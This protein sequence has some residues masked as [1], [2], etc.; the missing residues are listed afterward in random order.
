NGEIYGGV[1]IIEDITER[2][3][4]Q[5][6]QYESEEKYRLIFENSPL[7]IIS[8]DKNGVITACNTN[9][10]SIIG[11]STE[12]LVGLNMLNLPDKQMIKA[13][14]DSLKGKIG[15]YEGDYQSVTASKMTPVRCTFSPIYN[16]SG[17]LSGGVG[18][19]EDITERK[20]AEQEI[21]QI[22]HHYKAIIE[23]APD[24]IVL[25]NAEGKFMDVSPS[26]RRIF[27]FEET[28]VFDI[29]PN[30]FTHPDDLPMVLFNLDKLTKDPSFVPTLEYRFRHRN[31]DWL[32]IESTFSN[33]FADPAVGAIII[34]FR[35]INDRKN[36]EADLIESETKYRSLVDY[37]PDTIV[38]HVNG[39]IV[40]VNEAGIQLVGAASLA[41][42]LGKSVLEFVHPDSRA[43]VIERMKQVLRAGAPIP[44][45]EEVFLRLDGSTVEVDVK[46]MPIQYG[47]KRA[48][49][50]IIR[51][52]T[53]RKAAEKTIIESEK[54]YKALFATSPS[55][56]TIIDEDGIIIEINQEITNITG[57]LRDELVGQPIHLLG[58]PEREPLVRDNI[59]RILA[60]ETLESEVVTIKK[61]GTQAFFHL[62]E[63]AIT[64]PN[65][66]QGILSVSNDI[67]ARKEIEL[68]LESKMNDLL[69]FQRLTTGREL[70][71]IELK[72][73]I[74]NLLINIGKSPKYKIVE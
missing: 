14:G 56:I 46:S 61:D 15:L 67:S 68:E 64:L 57:Y 35:D 37:S 10:V 30:D 2:V 9:F 63:A 74:N 43:F 17:E 44:L 39:E 58:L 12:K 11:S 45:A 7:G 52:I 13:V 34:N 31:G 55:G 73:E 72:K 18:I 38:I 29:L 26:A 19:I 4:A 1:G 16:L 60:G 70:A 20:L 22:V 65:G 23:N 32:W 28:D 53:E 25:I 27:G 6:A 62:R 71:M 8:F 42:V 36:N 48:A 59:R 5:K 21:Q 50:L 51:D 66:Q 69:Q 3:N 40:F 54:R 47:D 41:D 33:A 24:G 49:Q